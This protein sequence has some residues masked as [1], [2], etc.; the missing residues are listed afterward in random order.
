TAGASGKVKVADVVSPVDAKVENLRNVIIG[1]ADQIAGDLVITEK[2]DGVLSD[3]EDLLI[4][5]PSGVKFVGTPKVEVTSG[6]LRIGTVRVRS[7]D[8]GSDSVLAIR[9][10]NDSTEASTIRISNI[11]LNLDRTVPEGSLDV[12]IK[13]AAVVTTDAYEDWEGID[14]VAKVAIANV[15]TPA[16]DA[17][18]A[19][20]V[21]TVDNT[22]YTVNGVEKTADVAPY[23]K[24]GRTFLP[25]RYVAEA[26]GVSSDNILWDAATKTVT[27][28]KGDRV[29]KLK[30]GSKVLYVNGTAINMDVAPEIKDGRTMLPL[31]W[32]GTALGVTVE[33]DEEARTVT[34]K[35]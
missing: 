7:G 5:L 19:T 14:Y 20:V 9:I 13:G 6:D 16:P 26:L 35:Q 29:V 10:E 22:K 31:R 3:D 8:N 24:D 11:R 1:A 23:I 15:V 28:F 2:E 18:K 34:V 12:E 33:W 27:L 4:E 17:Q 25:V 32:V 30:I 21:F